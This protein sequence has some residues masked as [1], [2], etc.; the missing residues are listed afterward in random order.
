MTKLWNLLPPAVVTRAKAILAVIGGVA[1][2]VV[3][4]FPSV[5]DDHWVSV[6]IAVLTALGVYAAPNSNTRS[7]MARLR[8]DLKIAL[9]ENRGPI[10]L[11]TPK[12]TRERIYGLGTTTYTSGAGSVSGIRIT[13]S[14]EGSTLLPPEEAP[15]EPG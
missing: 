14:G 8:A 15:G 11:A 2:V 9:A 3:S 13:Y 4:Y 10:V 12:E 5:A 1:Y 6:A 7:K